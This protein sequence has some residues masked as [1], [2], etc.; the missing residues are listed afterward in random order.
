MDCK[1]KT[2]WRTMKINN[3]SIINLSVNSKME[4]TKERVKFNDVLNKTKEIVT[5]G[6]QIASGLIGSPVLSMVSSS[7]NKNSSMSSGGGSD[8]NSLSK[9]Q[10]D[11]QKYGMEFLKIQMKMQEENRKFSTVSNINKAKHDTAKAAISNI[12]V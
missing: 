2:K 3:N 9:L 5:G 8:L 1:G 12:R 6:V 11:S 10:G 4:N 7:I